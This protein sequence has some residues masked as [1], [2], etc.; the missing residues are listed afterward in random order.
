MSFVFQISLKKEKESYT[1]VKKLCTSPA[2]HKGMAI[3]I[4]LVMMQQGS[5]MNAVLAYV[6]FIFENASL[7]LEPEVVPIL[8]GVTNL[9]ASLPAPF[10]VKK[11]GYKIVFFVSAFG[12]AICLVSIT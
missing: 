3:C 11:C 4:F 1:G 5:G 10:L 9:V 7:H 6:Q 12:S 8:V 2:V